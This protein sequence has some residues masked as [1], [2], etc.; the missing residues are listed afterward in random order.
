MRCREAGTL[1]NAGRLELRHV[2]KK[3][4]RRHFFALSKPHGFG[5]GDRGYDA[6]RPPVPRPLA[7]PR[8]FLSRM[9]DIGHQLFRDAPNRL[10][11]MIE[12]SVR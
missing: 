6:S 4:H 8:L 5:A 10:S 12:V 3:P 11:R 7:R 2:G 9:G 1:C